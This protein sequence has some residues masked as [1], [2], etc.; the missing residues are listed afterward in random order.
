MAQCFNYCIRLALSA[1]AWGALPLALLAQPANNEACGA[2]VLTVQNLDCEPTITYSW[3][4]ATWSSANGNTYC[5]GLQNRDVW[6]KA[7]VPANGELKVSALYANSDFSMAIEVYKGTSCGALTLVTE[8]VEGFPCIY[9]QNYFGEQPNRVFKN[10][11]PGSELYLRVYPL[12]NINTANA[13]IKLCVSN[14]ATLSNE[15][16]DAGFFPIDNADPLG[17]ECTPIKEFAWSGAT[18]SAGIPNPDC[19]GSMNPSLIR[20]VW[21]RLKVPATGKLQLNSQGLD[22]SIAVQVFSAPACTGPFTQIGCILGGNLRWTNLVPG[23]TLYV[24]IFRW[25][26][27]DV[28]SGKVKLCATAY[29][30]VPTVNNDQGKVGI[31][32]DTPFT[33]L[34]VVGAGYFHD[35]ILAGSDI[36]TRGNLIVKGNI[37]NSTGNPVNLPGAIIRGVVNIQGTAT[38]DSLQ[39]GS[40]LGNRISL[41]GGLGAVNQYGF[42]IQGSLLQMYTDAPGANIGFGYGYSGA[43]TERVRI[44]NNGENGMQINGRV[45]LRNGTNNVTQTP[46]IWFHNPDNTALQGFVGIQ[47]ANSMGFYSPAGGV[48]WGLNFFTATGNVGL[49]TT[50]APL[51]R[52][53]VVGGPSANPTKVVIGNRGGFGPTA[54]EMISDYGL[55]SQWT[56]ARMVTN[57]LGGF[58]GKLEF[59]TNIPGQLNNM[60]KG[61]EVRN[62]AAF[63]ATGTVS[64]WSDSRIKQ[65][66][67]PFTD[68]L[69]IIEQIQPVQFYYKP[70]APFNSANRQVGV[71]AQD[72]EKVAPYMVHTVADK[73]FNDL[74]FVDNQAYTFLLINAVKQLQQ[75]VEQLQKQM[76]QIQKQQ[77][78]K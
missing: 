69:Q 64:S 20:D 66:I 42:G 49:G 25:T 36:E 16:C 44:I 17:Q 71:L 41:Y 60:V 51:G 65:Q 18:L 40:R 37:I 62:G 56:P 14:T 48:G 21:M 67:Q 9:T 13:S 32:I 28:P 19:I 46:G 74:R 59:Y 3:T 77:K 33:K 61:L 7:M 38:I 26:G 11:T 8:S 53:D 43:F 30:T 73:G 39:M 63:T 24:R 29:N 52:F 6:F 47:N 15:P 55:A 1:I 58:H 10:L 31:G 4:G 35:K 34:Q 50:V 72:L 45:I 5:N 76:E 75:Q 12:S 68:G 22:G 78:Q 23:S 57:D 70:D 54:I 2:T 27:G